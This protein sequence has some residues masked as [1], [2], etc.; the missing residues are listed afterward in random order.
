MSGISVWYICLKCESEEKGV[1]YG[2]RKINREHSETERD[3]SRMVR[4]T[5]FQM[6]VMWRNMTAKQERRNG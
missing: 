2:D 6:R 3:A 1:K 4:E 5:D